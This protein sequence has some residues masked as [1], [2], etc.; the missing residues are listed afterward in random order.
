[1]NWPTFIT[2]TAVAVLSGPMSAGADFIRLR[3]QKTH[4]GAITLHAPRTLRMAGRGDIALEQIAHAWLAP[5][6][7]VAAGLQDLHYREYRGQW[8]A[9]PDFAALKPL[10]SA[11]APQNRVVFPAGSPDQLGLVF[12]GK[13]LVPARGVQVFQLG[14]AD[15]SRL[16][17]DG[18]LVVDNDGLHGPRMRQGQV[19]LGAGPHDFQLHYFNQNAPAFLELEWS[20]PGVPATKL[21]GAAAELPVSP[22]TLLQISDGLAV[23]AAGAMAW[24]GSFI[25]LP[26]VAMDD[27]RVTF[28]G[29]PAG[30][31]MTTINAAVLIFSPLTPTRAH[32]LRAGRP[33]ALLRSGE[34]IEGKIQTIADG[35]LV[36]QSVVLGRRTLV[37]G[38]DVVAVVL[39]PFAKP[40][41]RYTLRTRAGWVA[42][43]QTIEFDNNTVVI[44]EAPFR[45]H[46]VPRADLLEIRHG[47]HPNLLQAAWERWDEAGE[48]ARRIWEIRET[49]ID[50]AAQT[51]AQAVQQRLQL[52]LRFSEAT[53]RLVALQNNA[54]QLGVQ[55][56]QLIKV[57]EQ[58]QQVMKE[59][60]QIYTQRTQETEAARIAMEKAKQQDTAAKQALQLAGTAHTAAQ[61]RETAENKKADDALIALTAAGDR[62]LKEVDGRQQQALKAADVAAQ[63]F[64]KIT[65]IKIE[66]QAALTVAEQNLSAAKVVLVAANKAGADAEITLAT[67][68]QNH[69]AAVA[70]LAQTKA[71]HAAAQT[72]T[73]NARKAFEDLFAVKLKPALARQ[74]KAWQ[75]VA[76]AAKSKD[77]AEKEL[78]EINQQ[79][80]A[81][82]KQHVM[83]Q[84][85]T[86]E[87]EAAVAPAKTKLDQAKAVFDQSTRDLPGRI[88]QAQAARDAMFNTVTTQ[89][90]PASAAYTAATNAL[91][92]GITARMVADKELA[93]FQVA[94]AQAIARVGVLELAALT[95]EA[96][97]KLIE[98]DA[99]QGKPAK[100]KA[101]AEATA[102]REAAA[103][104]K[105]ARE[106][107]ATVQV[108][109]ATQKAAAAV[110]VVVQAET[111]ALA[112]K[113][114]QDATNQVVAAAT[115]A[116]QQMDRVRLDAARREQRAGLVLADAQADLDFTIKLAGEK[117]VLA[118][119][120]KAALDKLQVERQQ[121]ASLRVA[122]QG[123]ELAKAQAEH[124]AATVA[125]PPING[126][127]E[128][129]RQAVLRADQEWRKTEAAQKAAQEKSDLAQTALT[130]SETAAGN[131]RK[132][133]QAAM[134]ASTQ[135]EAAL[136]VAKAATEQATALE[137]KHIKPASDAKAVTLLIAAELARRKTQVTEEIQAA[138]DLQKRTKL[139]M[140]KEVV[141]STTAAAKATEMAK[142][143][144]EDSVKSEQAH[145]QAI[146]KTK[147]ALADNQTK[148]QA[149]TV[150][151]NDLAQ[152]VREV[153][154]ARPLI[155]LT[156]QQ[157]DVAGRDL[158]KFLLAN[159][160]VL[161]LR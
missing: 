53:Q 83:L 147:A 17:L 149:H 60:S 117:K 1:M 89:Q 90:Q 118:A 34:F 24:N 96:D 128:V 114:N 43:A 145:Q 46:R 30:V 116:F 119:A 152:K 130:T 44:N 104:A 51:Q 88:Q 124:I 100:D 97:A 106:K 138:V 36:L 146:E 80:T 69:A 121:P 122:A 139:A 82:G 75:A 55:E 35:R 37:L 151:L 28:L 81:A 161:Q 131:R 70:P 26:V 59:A 107:L 10:S 86:T 148:Q 12:E 47:Q 103:A 49:A 23:P 45:Q 154:A 50:Q 2:L 141:D 73:A 54:T 21:T 76:A 84:T 38:A 126:E 102:K 108:P 33:G 79:M 61:A 15:G 95:A 91:A 160:A 64:T 140:A 115:V 113:K 105:S 22:S 150:A 94:L 8:A 19:E 74:E 136:V 72:I 78:V 125:M 157:R 135:A 40:A 39:Q 158:E 71:A 25:P 48:V 32:A 62:S 57:A 144:A 31:E 63:T 127:I 67:A 132:E 6:A 134:A 4:E 120:A 109:A 68:K 3:D 159:R 14:S 56:Q 155:E 137:A 13:L 98:A 5:D 110:Q 112:A 20:G 133:A 143:A 156:A 7:P 92:A 85:Y 111:V 129:A 27:S 29:T 16:Y 93:D 123:Q 11:R 42:V 153:H 87:T 58:A 9:L 101:R 65:L 41:A 52:E 99:N 18:K 77:A 66:A 142:V